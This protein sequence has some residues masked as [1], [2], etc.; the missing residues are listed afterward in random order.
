[1]MVLAESTGMCQWTKEG[2]TTL[3]GRQEPIRKRKAAGKE[4]SHVHS[5]SF[6]LLVLVGFV[7]TCFN[8]G[9]HVGQ[10]DLKPPMLPKLPFNS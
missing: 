9:S 6:L 10:P 5:T 8:T 1:M 7:V 4:S 3:N 2:K